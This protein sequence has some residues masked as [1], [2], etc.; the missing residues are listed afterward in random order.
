[1]G[2]ALACV[3]VLG[4][5]APPA[6]AS[7]NPLNKEVLAPNPN[8]M[9][10][11]PPPD[12]QVEGA[13]G[14]AVA[15]GSIY[16]SEY[17]R[18]RVDLFGLTSGGFGGKIA[19][20]NPLDGVC[21]LALAGSNLYANEWHEGV[22]RLLPSVKVFDT[23]HESTGVATDAAANV[24]ALNRDYVAVYQPS[25]APV[26]HEGQPLEI[27]HGSLGDAYGIACS[28][29]R[30]YVADAA[31]NSIKVFEPAVDPDAPVQTISHGFTSLVDSALAV[32]PSSGHLVVL[33]NLQPGFEHPEAAIDEFA[34]NGTFLD[35]ID[36]PVPIIHGGPSGLAFDISGDLFVTTGNSEGSNVMEF[37]PYVASL[38]SPLPLESQPG[39]ASAGTTGTG[40]AGNGGA[41]GPPSES[42]QRGSGASTSEVVQH[43]NVRVALQA[44][45]TPK[46]LPREGSA[47]VH[48]SVSARIASSDG[49]VPPQLR[50]IEVAINRNGHIHPGALPVC[51]I[52]EIQ[53]ASTKGAL[54]ACRGSLVGE[55]SFSAKVLLTQQSPFPSAGEVIAFNGSWRG[56]PAILAHIFGTQ[57]VPT[58]YTLPFVIGRAGKGPYGTA[59]KASLPQFTSK[60]GYMTGISLYLGRTVGRGGYLTAG[61]PAPKGFGGASFSLARAKLAFTAGH[62]RSVQQTLTRS[63][64]VR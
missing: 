20:P 56:H 33:D 23:G 6:Q 3:L 36:S 45:L 32:D 2:A 13:C 49:S 18:S 62:P 22:V 10:P 58:S 14:A 12:G 21:G 29:G 1:M 55:G 54:E 11:Q 8:P 19:A 30:V 44:K 4:L 43:G 24:Y 57:P 46:K 60:W 61:C 15:G 27:G 7:R 48:F 52:D 34:A 31:S 39:A 5:G 35:Q 37:G 38:A 53:P 47:P 42:A 26:L 59:L 28:G 63:C 50:S 64:G 51:Q 17:Y 41:G 9:N 25:G 40:Q 16:V